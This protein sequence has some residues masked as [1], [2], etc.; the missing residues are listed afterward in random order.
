MTSR[1]KDRDALVL[2]GSVLSLGVVLWL[3]SA[4]LAHLPAPIGPAAQQFS[5]GARVTIQLTLVSAVFGLLLGV[6]GALGKL[7]AVAPVRWLADLF[8]WVIRGTPLLLQ[9]LFFYLAL[10]AVLPGVQ[11]SE[12][13]TAVVALSLNVGAYN[14]E[15]IRAGINAVPSGQVEAARSLGLSRFNTFRDITFPQAVRISLPPLANNLVAL[16]KDSSL[17]YAIGVV[18][19]SM[20]SSRVQA[21]SFQPVPV[22]LTVAAIYLVLTTTF[23]QFAGAL[24]RKLAVGKR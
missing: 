10:P 2:V 7:S 21:E 11:L 3:M 19:L 13:W 17:A 1:L 23:T 4:P 22:F 6:L 18:E 24:E 16:L 9:I 12:F 14:A 20:V 15:V 5:E 8:V